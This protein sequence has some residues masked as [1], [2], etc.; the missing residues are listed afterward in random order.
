MALLRRAEIVKYDNIEGVLRVPVW[1]PLPAEQARAA[2]LSGGFR[3]S[4]EGGSLVFKGV[5]WQTAAAV[6]QSVGQRVPMPGTSP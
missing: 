3:C 4:I 1:A 5:D 2:C 6:I